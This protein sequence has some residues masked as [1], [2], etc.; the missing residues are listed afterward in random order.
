MDSIIVLYQNFQRLR[1]MDS[2]VSAYEQ[3]EYDIV[4]YLRLFDLM[5]GL[6]MTPDQVA[7]LAEYGIKLP[8]LGNMRSEL[9]RQV[10]S[11]NSQKQQLG[12]QLSP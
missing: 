3:V 7:Q 10:Q 11:L 4:P 8:F 12:I 1:N 2:F 6:G 9:S 5:N